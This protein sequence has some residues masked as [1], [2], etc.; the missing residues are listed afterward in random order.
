MSVMLVSAPYH[1]NPQSLLSQETALFVL[2]LPYSAS[3]VSK[4]MSGGLNL[5][6]AELSDSLSGRDSDELAE[7]EH[8][9]HDK[10]ATITKRLWAPEEDAL[11]LQLVQQIGPRRWS[12]IASRLPGRVGKQCRERWHNHL[13]PSVKKEDWTDEED[14]LIMELVQQ[15]GTKWSK[16]VKM[17]PGRTDNAVKNRWN[18]TMRKNLRKQLKESGSD[19]DDSVDRLLA[20]YNA[21]DLPARKRGSATSAEMA[22]AAAVAAVT[23]AATASYA[24]GPSPR[25]SRTSPTKR[26]RSPK[27]QDDAE[28]TWDESQPTK[29][30]RPETSAIDAEP[31]PHNSTAP[32][33]ATESDPWRIPDSRQASM[34]NG[35]CSSFVEDAS[36]W[37]SIN[38]EV[39]EAISSNWLRATRLSS[40]GLEDVLSAPLPSVFDAAGFHNHSSEGL[41]SVF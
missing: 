11:L 38:F 35:H 26:K 37:E 16:I 30:S 20:E 32:E 4:I 31:L 15:W 6:E 27:A 22:T 21:N 10:G 2:G 18:S 8:D 24:R 1:A 12:T 23:A 39:E 19:L 34:T 7:A 3:P 13:C 29:I 14:Q 5:N 9:E 28:G 17:L 33:C 41:L 36:V 40:L 25:G